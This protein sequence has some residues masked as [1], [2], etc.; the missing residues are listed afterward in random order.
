MRSKRGACESGSSTMVVMVIAN[1]YR[2]ASLILSEI[3]CSGACQK[4]RTTRGGPK[5]AQ[6]TNSQ[7]EM[8]VIPMAIAARKTAIDQATNSSV[9]VVWKDM[10]RV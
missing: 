9:L 10:R 2:R 4:F 7:F 1:L 8:D 3:V 6:A 5:A